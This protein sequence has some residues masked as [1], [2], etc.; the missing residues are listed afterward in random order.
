MGGVETAL[1]CFL[2]E[3]ALCPG[4]AE[5]SAVARYRETLCSPTNRRKLAISL[6]RMARPSPAAR[7]SPYV[8]WDRVALV[9][10]E[11]LA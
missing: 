1:R 7:A 3:C 11:L 9:R 6:R 8:L 5:I 4:L 10:D 2:R